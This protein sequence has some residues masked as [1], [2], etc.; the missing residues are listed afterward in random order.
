MAATGEVLGRRRTAAR[1]VR[2]RPAAQRSGI[3]RR[4]AASVT[5]PVADEPSAVDWRRPAERDG[6]VPPRTAGLVRGGG[7]VVDT[8][9]GRDRKGGPPRTGVRADPG[10][11]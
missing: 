6:L 5:I 9:D 7:L 8:R 11:N 3:D 1:V 4:R 10:A 2:R